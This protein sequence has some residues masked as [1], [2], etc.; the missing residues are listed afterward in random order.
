M[1]RKHPRQTSFPLLSHRIATRS[2]LPIRLFCFLFAVLFAT[3]NPPDPD[4]LFNSRSFA[5]RISPFT[6]SPSDSSFYNT[7]RA[8]CPY[9]INLHVATWLDSFADSINISQTLNLDTVALLVA[10][11]SL[12]TNKPNPTFRSPSSRERIPATQRTSRL[13]MRFHITAALVA[14]A[15][16]ITGT[17]ADDHTSQATITYTRT[18]QRVVQTVTATRNTASS[19]MATAVASASM[20]S[21][22]SNGTITTASLTAS[23]TPAKQTSG[24]APAINFEMLGMAAIAGLA[25]FMA[26]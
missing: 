5:S 14:A 17:V 16:L 7:Q 13:T 11:L 26:L 21:G 10:S 12:S 18:V 25:G 3:S 23:S 20:A 6:T 2:L 8:H 19:S 22:Y 1:L 15:T 9:S 24:A 4:G